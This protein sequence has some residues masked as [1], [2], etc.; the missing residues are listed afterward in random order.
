MRIAFMSACDVKSEIYVMNADGTNKTRLTNNGEADGSPA[1]SPDGNSIAFTSSRDGN[2]ELYLMRPDG[3]NQ[4]RLTT[5]RA[6]D[7]GAHWSPDGKTL[8]VR[9][10]RGKNYD[11]EVIKVPIGGGPAKRL[12]SSWS[13]DPHW[14][15]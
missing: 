11:I 1:W 7:D 14:S 4:T 2:R 3:Q 6:E 15:R 12:T 9:A 13:L 8:V 10:I 5:D